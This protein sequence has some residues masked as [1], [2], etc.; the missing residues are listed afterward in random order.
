MNAG[1]LAFEVYAGKKFMG[2]GGEPVSRPLADGN[3][4][5]PLTFRKPCLA[6]CKRDEEQGVKKYLRARLEVCQ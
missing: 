4:F 6:C 1:K 2:G 5:V 3:S